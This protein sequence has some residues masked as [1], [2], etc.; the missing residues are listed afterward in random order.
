LRGI[1]V[2]ID[3]SRNR[4]GGAKA[5]LI[6]I[7][8]EGDPIKYGIKEIHLWSFRSLLD[9][10]P[11]RSWLV[12]HNPRELEQP[13][14]RQLWWQST[15]LSREVTANGCDIL[16]STDAS[17]LCRFGPMVVLSQDMLSYEP[18]VMKHFGYTVARLRLLV[19]WFVQNRAFQFA[20]GVIFLTQYAAKLIQ[21]SCGSLSRIALIP[22]G[23]GFDFKLT[24]VNNAWPS[25]AV[26]PI[27]CIYVSNAEMY[28]HQ[29]VVIRGIAELRSRGYNIIITLVGGGT[30]R[31]QQMLD[32][33]CIVSDPN[34][35][36]VERLNFIPQKE[37]PELLASA[38]LF[39]FASGCENM[40]VTLLEAM[41]VGLPIACSNRGPMPEVLADGGT[42]FDPEDAGSIADAVEQIIK[43]PLLR[44]RIAQRAKSISEQYSWLR[45]SDQTWAFIMETYNKLKK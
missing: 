5:H 35:S 13:L 41:A 14:S 37:L 27:R 33:Q 31:A 16:F 43:D 10:I 11:D 24:K 4:S 15:R 39:V 29:W 36:F 26:R 9:S 34:G 32:E 3:A 21:K 23:V 12:K 6:G 7:L 38:D 44:L 20:D 8:T 42:Y 40:P 28:K 19:I 18:G 17:T 45:C 22:H 1:T 2:G 25:D 30:G